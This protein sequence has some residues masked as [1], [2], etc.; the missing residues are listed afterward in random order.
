MGSE[1]SVRPRE[2]VVRST[3]DGR[4][5]EVTNIQYTKD[6]YDFVGTVSETVLDSIH[7][8]EVRGEIESMDWADQVQRETPIT[9]TILG[10]RIQIPA[11]G[12]YDKKYDT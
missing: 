9:E 7:E 11:P 10:L 6:K 2:C 12:G 4:K 5:K 3:R 8:N 1:K